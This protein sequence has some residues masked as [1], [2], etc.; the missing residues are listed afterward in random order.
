MLLIVKSPEIKFM[1]IFLESAIRK[2]RCIQPKKASQAEGDS[3]E[4]PARLG[5][6]SR[7]P[8]ARMPEGPVTP[9][10]RGRRATALSSVIAPVADVIMGPSANMVLTGPL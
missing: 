1:Q 8:A 10:A 4:V 6:L 5:V 9:S 7:T 3:E 2:G